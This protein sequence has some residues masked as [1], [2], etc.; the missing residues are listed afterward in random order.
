MNAIRR[1]CQPAVL[2]RRFWQC[3]RWIFVLVMLTLFL[4]PLYYTITLSLKLEVDAF[5]YPPKWIFKPT[6]KNFVILFSEEGF[7]H[8]L[9]NS[10]FISACCVVVSMLF[11]IPMAYGL[12][13][14]RARW[15]T[16]VMFF[17]LAMR[18]MPP[19]SILIPTFSVYVKLGWVDTYW[20]VVLMYLT[21]TMPMCLWMLKNGFDGIPQGIEEAGRID[22]C[23]TVQ[24]LL[25]VAGPIVAEAMAAAAILVWVY[26]WNEFLY[27]LILTRNT[28]KTAPVMINSFMNFESIRWGEISAAAVVISS[29]VVLF[30]VLVRRYLVSGL[31]AGALKE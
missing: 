27:A 7:G 10:M 11:G 20:G 12:S 23:S 25:W 24:V 1:Q 14:C 30:G 15:V 8:Y 3:A 17:I 5:A 2:K 18:V 26:S 16:P 4:F 31:S 6:F 19:M 22:G 29:P 21:F 28:T 13:R 9:L